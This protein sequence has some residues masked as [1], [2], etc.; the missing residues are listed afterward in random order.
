MVVF[1]KKRQQARELTKL[2]NERAT[3]IHRATTFGRTAEDGLL[4]N[5]KEGEIKQKLWDARPK[6]ARKA[7]KK[8][9]YGPQDEQIPDASSGEPDVKALL[10]EQRQK[11][12]P[13]KR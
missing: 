13:P 7:L 8:D 2:F 9:G 11:I 12:K 6:N 3:L 4:I 10:Q 1:F 5:R